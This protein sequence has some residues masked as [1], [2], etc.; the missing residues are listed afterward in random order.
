MMAILFI[1]FPVM[2]QILSLDSVF[3]YIDSNNPML[4]EFDEKIKAQNAY[5]EGANSWMAPMVGVGPYWFP[6][7]KPETHESQGMYMAQVEQ[8]IPNPAKI[9]A[10]R[11]YLLSMGN[12]QVEGRAFRFNELKSEAKELYYGSIIALRQLAVLDENKQILEMMIKLARIRYPYNQGSLGSIYKA[13]ARLLEIEN[14]RL[15]TEGEIEQSI[16]RLKSLMDLSPSRSVSVDTT[17]LVNFDPKESIDLPDLEFRRSDVRQLD[18]TIKTMRLNQQLQ[19]SSAK[20]DFRFRFEHMQPRNSSMPT[21]FSAM[22]MISIPIAPWASKMYKSEVKGMESEIAS[23]QKG[24][25]AILLETKGMLASMRIQL[26]RMAQQLDN[27]QTKIL[28]A[29]KKNYQV[30]MLAYEENREQLPIVIDGWEAYTMAK[31]EYL[32][33]QRDYYMMIVSYEK[34]LEK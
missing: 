28:P 21:Q 18:Q 16:T 13:E 11:N 14:M 5:A 19:Q 32:N 29:L 7:S 31:M 6:Y 2:A 15:M 12:I 26:Q 8:D 24:R 20:P 9:K 27:Y 4:K 22:A 1:Q 25:E 10:K 3:Y 23:M 30:T 34:A 33:K 17:T